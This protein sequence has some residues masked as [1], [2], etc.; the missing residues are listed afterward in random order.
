MNEHLCQRVDSTISAIEIKLL[1]INLPDIKP[2]YDAGH[3]ISIVDIIDQLIW[4]VNA[5]DTHLDWFRMGQIV[6]RIRATA[7][8]FDLYRFEFKIL[9]PKMI[10]TVSNNTIDIR[11]NRTIIRNLV[12]TFY[13][14]YLMNEILKYRL[15][16]NSIQLLLLPLY[17]KVFSKNTSLVLF[18]NTRL[19]ITIERRLYLHLS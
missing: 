18:S 6:I 4:L 5:I 8:R 17:D 13:K 2:P 16:V 14:D 3:H 15:V 1:I 11:Y 12:K 7:V 10:V 9:K 19:Y